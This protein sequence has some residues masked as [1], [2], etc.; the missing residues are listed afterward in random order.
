MR[1]RLVLLGVAAVVVWAVVAAI[2]MARAASDLSAGRDAATRARA[3][4]DAQD[5]ADR[6]PL[7]HLRT[8]AKRFS[9]AHDLAGGVVLA[10]LRVLPVVGRQLRSV[11]AL[12]GAAAR[13]SRAG[14]DAVERAGKVFDQPAA[15]GAG[16]V[17]QVRELR[18]IV[19]AAATAVEAV[20]D[21]GPRKGLVGPLA[22]AR[23]QLA[24][25]L[26]DAKRGLVDARAGSKAAL[27]LVTGP[28]RYL[29][30]AANNAEMRAGSGMWLQGGVLTTKDG[31]LDLGEMVSL[32]LDAEPPAGAVVPTGDLADRWGFLE[33]GNE[34]RSLM[35]SPNFPESARLATEMWKA[36]GRGEVDGVLAV[37]AIGLRSILEATGPA[38]VGDR[39][40][41]PQEVAA[42]VLHDQYREFAS[43]N[44]YD[45]AAR[46][47][48]I[49]A[50]A[51][52]AVAAVNRG[53]YPASTLIRTLGFGIGGRH[54]L[55][56]TPDQVE[57]DGWK[58]AG[59]DGELQPDSL[60]LSVLNIGSNKLDWFLHVD[61]SLTA[62]R[63]DA[64]WDVA[65]EITV[66]NRTP[67][68]G[69][70]RYVVGP[71]PG[72]GFAP[73]EYQGIL[74]VN[75]PGSAQHSRFDGTS[76]LAVAGADGKTRVV[77]LVLGLQAGESRTVVLRF[78][79][80][81]TADHVVIEPSA[82]VPAVQWHYGSSSWKDSAPHTANWRSR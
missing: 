17:R 36:S 34:W 74:A 41:R 3:H 44:S 30:L 79:V 8:A 10:P 37:D 48:A 14:V 24:G 28:R 49:G 1:R 35:A 76:A 25:D 63:T 54:L 5:I 72:S 67:K 13:V 59:M 23:N 78:S 6:T 33:P 65:V 69:E 46:K 81:R 68:R 52:S 29:V 82:R 57:S 56:W 39:T 42:F 15:A 55:A 47:E 45:T 11:D 20:D 77:G 38:V 31:E 26:E 73:G 27:A 4:I 62:E 66:A 19:D 40:I 60:L 2:W 80:P 21:L 43:P 16:R 64:G 22:D 51:R 53:D 61:A 32:P 9:S 18:D 70:P 71:Y 7:P 12:S 50:L 58:A 75:V